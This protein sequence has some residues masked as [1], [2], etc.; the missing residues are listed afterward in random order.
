VV[1][2]IEWTSLK[3]STKYNVNERKVFS[4]LSGQISDLKLT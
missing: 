4:F 1:K 3:V 2:K